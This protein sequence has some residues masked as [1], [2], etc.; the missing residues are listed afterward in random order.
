MFDINESDADFYR[1]ERWVEAVHQ[2]E[3]MRNERDAERA[4]TA[5]LRRIAKA[6]F[7]LFVE[8][9]REK[10]AILEKLDFAR[11]DIMALYDMVNDGIQA[12][13]LTKE[14]VNIPD[15]YGNVLL[16]DIEGWSHYDWIKRASAL[17]EKIDMDCWMERAEALI[18]KIDMDVVDE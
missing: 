2:C 18:D 17:I 1:N 3:R 4:K 11:A 8:A 12:F 16:P 13:R 14:Y 6:N 9:Q 7:N 5:Q 10:R 15:M